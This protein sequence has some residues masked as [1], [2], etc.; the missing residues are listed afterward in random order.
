MGNELAPINKAKQM[1]A[2][3]EKPIE[4][5]EYADKAKALRD[6]YARQTGCLDASNI[7]AEHVI[8]AEVRLGELAENEKLPPGRPPEKSRKPLHG[9]DGIAKEVGVA[10]RTVA[11]WQEESRIATE[12]L[13]AMNQWLADMRLA[14]KQITS[15][16]LRK[17]FRGPKE[18]DPPKIDFDPP[19]VWCS[20]QNEWI[21]TQ[22]DCDLLFTDPP[23]MTDVEDV[24]EFAME[25][26]PDWLNKVKPTGR[27]YVCIGAYPDELY[28]YL[29][30]QSPEHLPLEQVLVWTY[31]NTLGQNPNDKYKLNWQAIL[32]YKGVDA[33]RLDVKKTADQFA[34]FDINAP[35]GRLGD[36]CHTW[37]KPP[38]LANIIIQQATK[39]GDLVLDPFCCTGTF[40][41][42]ANKA[43]RIGRG[44]DI[45]QE[46]LDLAI[47]R[48]CIDANI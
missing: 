34:V 33:P 4:I 9:L 14:K 37:Q 17:F 6:F 13:D 7:A 44:C 15:D 35:D 11:N 48:G 25:W 26:M 23:Y 29:S 20:P 43:G 30:I 32:Y 22:P 24:G 1:L 2:A 18:Y 36:R 5:K 3:I 31:R 41:L 27:A 45:S 8:W 16:G 42:A 10:R 39:E 19:E 21:K 12:Q 28:A 38:A 46:N 40:I 47:K